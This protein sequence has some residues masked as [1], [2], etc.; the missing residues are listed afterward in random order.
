MDDTQNQ[1]VEETVEEQTDGT[2]TQAVD[3]Q[4]SVLLSLED[5]IKKYITKLDQLKI[6]VKKQREMY[7]DSFLNNP[8]FIEN[9]EKAK[10]A[11]KDLLVTKKNIA[12]QPSVVQI[13]LKMKSMREELKEIAQ[14]LSDYLQEYQ[15]LTGANEIEGEDGKIR[16]IVNSAKLVVR[17][18]K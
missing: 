9:T 4:A 10:A 12:S 17:S 6:E 3:N 5:M 1:P 18:G 11:A 13:A 16:D 8:T 2:A 15:R 7:D 14:S